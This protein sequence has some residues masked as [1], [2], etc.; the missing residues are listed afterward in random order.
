MSEKVTCPLCGKSYDPY[1][2]YR[3]DAWFNQKVN[4]IAD[5]EDVEPRNVLSTGKYE[6]PIPDELLG[7]V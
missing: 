1:E 3:K 7:L 6:M 2:A 5:M 4:V